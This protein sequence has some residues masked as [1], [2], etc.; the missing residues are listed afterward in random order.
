MPDMPL[1]QLLTLVSNNMAVA[2]GQIKT[3]MEGLTLNISAPNSTTGK[4]AKLLRHTLSIPGVMVGGR[5]C[6]CVCLSVW[7]KETNNV[8]NRSV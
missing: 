7:Q 4:P 1:G 5:L 2:I 3:T 6:L 8:H